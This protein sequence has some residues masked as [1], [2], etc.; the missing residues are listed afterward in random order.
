MADPFHAFKLHSREDFQIWLA[1]DVEARD[2]LYL[3]ML[4]LLLGEELDADDHFLG[5]VFG[6]VHVL[7]DLG[8][9]L[10]DAVLQE[11]VTPGD[12]FEGRLGG[13]G[14]ADARDLADHGHDVF[15]VHPAGAVQQGRSEPCRVPS[16]GGRGRR[17]VRGWRG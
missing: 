1:S 3:M 13:D 15:G 6:P 2:E 10:G 17:R 16:T 5:D 9:G 7:G 11:V 8:P 12:G 14:V 4:A